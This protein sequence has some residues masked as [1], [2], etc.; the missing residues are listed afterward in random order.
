MS[1]LSR[2]VDRVFCAVKVYKHV[3]CSG[4]QVTVM[5]YLKN[6]K[7]SIIQQ[8]CREIDQNFRGNSSLLTSHNQSSSHRLVALCM[9]VCYSV[10]YEK[11][12]YKLCGSAAVSWQNVGNLTERGRL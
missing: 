1:S 7:M 12:N 8:R 6:L 5:A 4:D 3:G 9:R 2:F 11:G 10:K